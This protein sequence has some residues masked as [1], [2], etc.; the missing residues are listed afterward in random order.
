[1]LLTRSAGAALGLGIGV[2]AF[3]GLAAFRPANLPIRATLT[4]A[5]GGLAVAAGLFSRQ[6]A[7]ML[8]DTGAVFFDKDP[9]LTGRTYLWQRAHE[10]IAEKPF[11]GRGYNA[12]WIQGNPDAEGLWRYAGITDRA[13]F[14]F[15][16]TALEILVHLGWLGLVILS[17]AAAVGFVAMVV[18][19]ITRPSLTWCFWL[20]LLVY[21]L[22]RMPVESIGL[23]PFYFST[24]LIFAGLGFPFRTGERLQPATVASFARVSPSADR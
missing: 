24:V 16:N 12:F 19:F 10:L 5:L 17:L 4:V 22:A 21:E 2:A 11:A 14:N 13:G 9:T 23:V 8:V 1:L 7:T 15:H 18:R 6:I 3:A 20:A